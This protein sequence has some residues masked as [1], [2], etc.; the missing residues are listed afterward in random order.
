MNL[1]Y[2]ILFAGILMHF[3]V[4]PAQAEISFTE[5]TTVEEWNKVL[6][7]AAAQD[8][9]VFV[10]VYT[11]WCGWCVKMDRQVYNLEEVGSFYNENFVNVKLDAEKGGGPEIMENYEIGGYPAY[12]FVQGDGGLFESS[13]GYQEGEEFLSLGEGIAGRYKLLPALISS[14]ND[15]SIS[16]ENLVELAKFASEMDDTEL[17][18]RIV[19]K[20]VE[21]ASKKELY[22][23]DMFSILA[24]NTLD[25]D[26]E[27]F[28]ILYD[29]RKKYEGVVG[30][31]AYLEAMKN[32]YIQNLQY[33]AITQDYSNL[34]NMLDMITPMLVDNNSEVSE[35]KLLSKLYVFKAGADWD[36]YVNFVEDL[37]K[38]QKGKSLNTLNKIVS[39]I[40]EDFDIEEKA[41]LF[42]AL[43][44]AEQAVKMEENFTTLF[45]L[46]VMQIRNEKMNQA[47]TTIGKAVDK[48]ENYKDRYR[49]EELKGLLE[50]EAGR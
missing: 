11:D 34:D 2:R 5:V 12:L 46:G 25:V 23:E 40:G 36:S 15:G 19:Q 30:E 35:L 49:A 16:R 38:T 33:A 20:Y 21:S 39:E 48:A 47:I 24:S 13:G 3:F 4:L 6:E 26:S 8:K 9:L 1:T 7:K 17:G 43:D 42:A 27:Y 44:W 10:D 37:I 45:N 28:K 29:G 50:K 31:L 14:F 22:T 41:F 32:I 18:E